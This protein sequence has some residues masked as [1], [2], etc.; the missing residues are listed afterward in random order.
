VFSDEEIVQ[1]L[2]KYVN[3]FRRLAESE[4]D[5]VKKDP[6]YSGYPHKIIVLVDEKGVT[7]EYEP[8]AKNFEIEIKRVNE[9]PKYEKKPGIIQEGF[10]NVYL[11]R[12]INQPELRAKRV[13]EELHSYETFQEEE[14]ERAEAEWKHYEQEK[15]DY[16]VNGYNDYMKK[17]YTVH[18][19]TVSDKKGE[20]YHT[21]QFIQNESIVMET[22]FN[23]G[24]LTLFDTLD[25]T[26][27]DLESSMFLAVHGKYEPAMGLLRRYFE[28]TL[29][30][31]YY[32]AELSSLKST[33]K[34]Y[35]ALNSK[36]EKWLEKSFH[37]KF[38]GPDGVL[39]KLLDPD[40][41]YIAKE[42]VK[43]TTL[44][45]RALNSSFQTYV[46]SKYQ[47][48]S[49]FIHYGGKR[50]TADILRIDFAEFSEERFKEWDSSFHQL[51]E[52]CN[53]LILLKFPKTGGNVFSGSTKRRERTCSVSQR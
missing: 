37:M 33:S 35:I 1:F 10:A 2:T 29:C 7:V 11:K 24:C 4:P 15:L 16:V 26:M 21:I 6:L 42:V 39:D 17:A 34:S 44:P 19:K 43:R 5:F 36:K 13:I 25:E 52:I 14:M 50:E 27:S 9:R 18:E 38:T 30:S 20:L 53:L 28:T 32:D 45:A 23:L 47:Y 40:T 51:I 48:L 41:D 12:I 3:E 46:E 8:N 22:Y 31:L 49:K